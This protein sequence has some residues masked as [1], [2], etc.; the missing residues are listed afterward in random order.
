MRRFLSKH[1]V[2]LTTWLALVCL[3]EIAAHLVPASQ[4][5]GEP[6]VPSWEFIFTDSLKALS[7]SWTGGLGAPSP[8]Y[9]GK[10]TYLGAFYAIVSSSYNTLM[11]LVLGL[12]VG[13]VAG[14]GTGFIVSY[15]PWFRRLLWT[16]M[17]YLRMCPLLAAIPLFQFWLGATTVGT[18]VFIAF[19]VWVLL[20]IS[21]LNSVRN[22]PDLYVESARTL[23]A[24]RLRVY[25][26]VVMP[27]ALP[28]LRTGLLLATGLSW[29]QSIGAEYLGVSGGLGSIMA[30]AET[31]TNTGR[32]M[33]IA[34]LIAFY[35]LVTFFILNLLLNKLVRWLPQVG[36]DS[37]LVRSA[38][39]AAISGTA[40]R[41]L[42]TLE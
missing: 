2:G 10:E 22:V 29:S 17:N 27:A 21:T 41:S 23:G 26:T 13:A 11:R 15:W 3:W 1:W 9:G 4:L 12:L 18:T 30:T 34:L 42:S 20:V 39:V 5:K 31:F 19:G 16:P 24:S 38:G 36:S 14:V 8:A 7:G 35:A 33:I 32:M 28:E 40:G 37:A 6:I 25:F